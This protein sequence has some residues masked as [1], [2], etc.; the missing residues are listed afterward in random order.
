LPQANIDASLHMVGNKAEVHLHNPS[1]TLAFQVAV[2]ADNA[3]GVSITPVLWSD[4]Y[5]ELTPGESITLSANLPV[6][7]DGKPVFR[8]SG[9]N[10]ATQTLHQTA[11]KVSGKPAE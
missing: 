1:K 3:A 6:P 7:L 11:A 9:W 4:N 5:V 8:V 2:S 10:I